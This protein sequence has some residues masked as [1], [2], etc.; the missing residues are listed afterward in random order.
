MEPSADSERP[1]PRMQGKAGKVSELVGTSSYPA[2]ALTS[3]KVEW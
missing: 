1:M 2:K 3:L